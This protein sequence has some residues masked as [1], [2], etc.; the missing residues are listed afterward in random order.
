MLKNFFLQAGDLFALPDRMIISDVS[1]ILGK[2][3]EITTSVGYVQNDNDQSVVEI[4]VSRITAT[5]R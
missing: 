4:V 3:R 2:V 1:E 5:L